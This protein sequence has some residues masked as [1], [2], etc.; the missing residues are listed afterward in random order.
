M[1]NKNILKELF[2]NF[3]WWIYWKVKWQNNLEWKEKFSPKSILGK[4]IRDNLA[5]F[6]LY[7]LDEQRNYKIN[8]TTSDLINEIRKLNGIE[9]LNNDDTIT[10]LLDR[11]NI[12]KT[13][14]SYVNIQLN[15]KIDEFPQGKEMYCPQ[16]YFGEDN[17]IWVDMDELLKKI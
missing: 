1:G 17:S 11:R 13:I 9:I 6:I 7:G 10:T 15:T 16:C 5:Y 4:Q 12:I 8:Q 14:N 3:G 2:T